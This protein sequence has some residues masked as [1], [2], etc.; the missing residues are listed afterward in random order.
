MRRVVIMEPADATSTTSTSPSATIPSPR[1]SPA[2]RPRS[3]F[4]PTYPASL[5][6]PRY[7]DGIPILDE[8]ELTGLIRREA[9]DE[10]LAYLRPRARDGHAQ[11]LAGARGRSGLHPAGPEV[12]HGRELD[13]GRRGL[14]GPDRLRQEPDQ[15]PGRPD[16]ARRR[17]LGRARSPS[18]A[19]RR[20][21]GDARA[22]VRHVEEIDASN[23]TVEERKYKTPVE[24]GMDVRRRRLRGDACARPRTR[25]RGHLGRREQRLLLL[26][27]ADFELGGR[28]TRPHTSPPT[29]P[30]RST[31]GWPTS[32]RNK[33]D[34]TSAKAVA[35][36][37][38]NGL[39]ATRMRRS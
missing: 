16:P 20:P 6:G 21:R 15:P 9:V 11:G 35:K 29:I 28:P 3:S 13:A 34:S 18:D 14:R 30:A 10:V 33:V 4:G 1:W 24:M 39:S 22:A 36:V 2:R 17:P 38:A 19:V 5:A 8:E 7:P 27:P 37:V 12:H 26:R 25:R 31:S 23:P 32:G